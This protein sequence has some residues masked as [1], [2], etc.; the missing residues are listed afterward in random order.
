MRILL[1]NN[2]LRQPGGSETWTLAMARTLSASHDVTVYTVDK[3]P[4]ANHFP[5]PVLDSL[6]QYYDLALVNHNSC[7]HEAIVHSRAVI[8]TSHGVVPTLEQPW[9]GADRYVAVSEEVQAH[10]RNLGFESCII[11]NGI[12]CTE[13]RPTSK[14]AGRIERL[15]S[16]CHGQHAIATL[17]K[18][19]RSRGIEFDYIH[20]DRMT[21]AV[22][23][24]MNWADVVVGLGRTAYE[25]MACG[26]AVLVMDSRGYM[27]PAMDGFVTRDSI[28]ELARFNLSGRRYKLPVEA[29]IVA[30]ALDAYRPEMGAFNRRYAE[31]NL[32]LKMTVKQYLAIGYDV[33]KARAV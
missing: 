12:D 30:A 4:F 9:P 33:L 14:P 23:D 25:A 2:H 17:Q 16:A 1:T 15:L 7:L 19:C 11:P 28:A 10:M 31:M 20:Q 29:H 21:M 32:N 18:V 13:F 24:R 26:R 22:A 8:F 27:P 6:T 5:C 3:G